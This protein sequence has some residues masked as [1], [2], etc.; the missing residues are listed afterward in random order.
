[1]L[2][3]V[4]DKVTDSYPIP[5]TYAFKKREDVCTS[6][7]F[8]GL[9]LPQHVS[10]VP[11]YRECILSH[12]SWKKGSWNV[13][14]LEQTGTM[15]EPPLNC[16][17]DPWGQCH[18]SELRRWPQRFREYGPATPNQGKCSSPLPH[19]PAILF[20]MR[21]EQPSHGRALL[22]FF[23]EPSPSVQ[24]LAS[25]QLCITRRTSVIEPIGQL[26]NWSGKSVAKH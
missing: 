18:L 16:L 4:L 10:Q 25:E 7:F 17:A 13:S 24:C 20:L 1:M 3:T 19:R 26:K 21:E 6:W 12:N 14:G 8:W 15:V 5:S 2:E 9:Y 22:M 23:K 11:C